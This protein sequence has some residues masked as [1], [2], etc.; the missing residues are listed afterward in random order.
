MMYTCFLK[1]NWNVRT[2]EHLPE[3]YCVSMAFASHLRHRVML[4]NFIKLM[5][6]C[7][8]CLTVYGILTMCFV[9][10]GYFWLTL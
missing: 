5:I 9:N 1:K 4:N 6:I 10:N 2:A 7:I 8:D 3:V